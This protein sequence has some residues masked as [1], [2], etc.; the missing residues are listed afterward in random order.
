M[1]FSRKDILKAFAIVHIFEASRPVGRVDALAVLAD[2]AGISYGFSQFT[3]RSGS[4]KKVCQKY[5][6]L[7]GTAGAEV[8]KDRLPHLADASFIIKYSKDDELKNA[9]R[10]AGKTALM[11]QA[12]EHVAITSYMN[13]AINAAEG[14]SFTLPLSL[15]VIYD[16]FNHGGYT[17][18][19]DKVTVRRSDFNSDLAFEKAWVTSYVLKRRAWLLANRK[20]IVHKTIYR[21]DFF[22]AQIGQ[23]NWTMNLPVVVHGHKLTAKDLPETA[24]G[25][26]EEDRG[27][28]GPETAGGSPAVQTEEPAAAQT[29]E[30][31][32]EGGEQAAAGGGGEFVAEDKPMDAPATMTVLGFA[33]PAFLVPIITGTKQMFTDGY[34]NAREIFTELLD[35]VKG[36][37]KW[38]FVLIAL[39]IVV[40]IVK[41][42]VRQVTLWVQ[43]IIA[44]NPNWHN[45]T[46][47]PVPVT[48]EWWQVWK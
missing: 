14:S 43:M 11:R 42:I 48:R 33:V 1:S 47:E 24:E 44:A 19:R 46:A 17:S 31:A 21:P 30:P 10:A 8:I 37:I 27:R 32:G 36:N 45:V 12:Q 34:L 6:Q 5:L 22:T 28:V 13:P 40:M 25:K 41:K 18:V 20:A 39:I 4:L 3:H 29:E 7:G 35:F 38:V 2:G 16:S 23:S 26:Q 9:L 15:A